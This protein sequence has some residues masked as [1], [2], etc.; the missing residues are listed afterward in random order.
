MTNNGDHFLIDT[1]TDDIPRVEIASFGYRHAPAP[2]AHI[3]LDLREGFRNPADDPAMVT[4]TGLNPRVQRHVYG[5]SLLL[6]TVDATVVQAMCMHAVLAPQAK[7]LRIAVGCQGGRH[8]SV[9]VA[10]LISRK[11]QV[12]NIS[13]E[14][15]H[16]DVACPILPPAR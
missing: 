11:L 12:A 2:A 4:L 6:E 7:T 5:T 15:V 3:T 9:A 8:R 1:P 10:E 16:R 14:V 13:N